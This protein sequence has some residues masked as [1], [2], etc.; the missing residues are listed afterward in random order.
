MKRA[1][2]TIVLVVMVAGI[3]AAGVVN[4]GALSGPVNITS[5]NLT[6]IDQVTFQY[7]PQGDVPGGPIMPL[8]PFDGTFGMAF[9]ACVGAQVDSAGLFGTT[10]GELVLGFG[11][12]ALQLQFDYGLFTLLTPPQDYGVAALF[13]RANSLN[14]LAALTGDVGTFSYLGPAFDQVH[15]Y[16]SPFDPFNDPTSGQPVFGQTF[17]S[18]SNMSYSVPEP[19]TFVLLGSAL[20]GLG[21]LL[22]RKRS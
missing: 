15:L 7:N 14:G 5:P 3:A 10:E 13:F 18:V 19:G 4:F 20:I 1:F 16:F 8:C 9:G 12:G 17:F 2:Q 11:A 22:R 6:S 21:C